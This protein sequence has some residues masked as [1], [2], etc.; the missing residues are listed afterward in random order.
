[1]LGGGRDPREPATAAEFLAYARP[2]TCKVVVDFRVGPMS[3][4]TETRVHVADPASRT[5]FRRYWVVV[6][7]F[8]GLIR[9]LLLRAARTR[10]EAAA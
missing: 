6:R 4:S 5:K 1:V 9:A 3:L 10:A 8:S 2:D 7:P